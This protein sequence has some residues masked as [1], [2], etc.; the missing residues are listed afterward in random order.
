MARDQVIQDPSARDLIEHHVLKKQLDSRPGG[1]VN[2]PPDWQSSPELPTSAEV[3][4]TEPGHLPE[5]SDEVPTKLQYLESQYWLTRFEGTELLRRAVNHIRARPNMMEDSDF[6]IYTQVHV[7]GYL[8]ARS[9]AACR[10]SFSTERSPSKVLWRHSKRLTPQTLVALSPRSDNFKSQCFVAVVAE[11][12]LNGGVEPNFQA[13][14][15]ENTPPRIEIFWANHEDAILDPSVDL[16]MV[17]AKGGYFEPI[18]HALVGLQHA[19]LYE[20]K[21]DKYIVEECERSLPAAYFQEA[22]QTVHFPIAASQFD[23]SQT[24]AFNCMTSRELAIVQGPPGTGKTFTSIVAIQSY[25]QTLQAN[26]G[27][28]EPPS[29]V[30]VSAQTNHALDQ[31]L[32]R[33]IQVGANVVRLG[34]RSK[35]A[36]ICERSMYNLEQGSKV[37]AGPAQGENSRKTTLRNLKDALSMCFPGGLISADHLYR[38]GLLSK[39]QF[40]SLRDNDWET[41]AQPSAKVDSP[42]SSDNPNDTEDT[43]GGSIT[44]WLEDC[45]E[46]DQTYVYRPPQGQAEVTPD[47]FESGHEYQPPE[48]E[49]EERERLKGE[50]VSTEFYWTGSVPGSMSRNSAWYFQGCKYLRKY[51]D[52]YQVKPPQ[53]GMV[54]R[55]LRQQLIE[56]ITRQFPKLLQV[57]QNACDDIKINKWN[58]Q[59]K[60]VQHEGIEVLGCTTT[61]LTKY[62]GLISAMKPRIL[63]IEEAA[64]TREANITSALYPSLDQVALVGD[65]QQLV[66][67]VDVSELKQHPYHLDVSLFERLVHLNLPYSMLKVQRRTIPIIRSVVNTFYPEIEDHESVKDPRI[68]PPVPGMGGQNL[69]WFQHQWG[70]S[71]NAERS[72]YNTNEAA[73]IVGFVK[74][75]VQNGVRPSQ[76]TVLTYYNGQVAAILSMLRR[77]ATLANFNPTKEWSVRTVDGFQGEENEIIILSLVRSPASPHHRPKAGFVENENRA[78]V[79]TSRARCGMYIFGNS[80]NLLKSTPESAETWQRVYDVFIKE[81]CIGYKLPVACKKHDRITEL[82]HPADWETIPGGGCMEPCNETCPEGHPCEAICHAANKAQV[83]CREMCEK[84]LPCN[85]RCGSFCG[86]PCECPRGCNKPALA[87]VDM[88]LRPPPTMAAG[89]QAGEQ[90][91]SSNESPRGRGGRGGRGAR[92]ARGAP[93]GAKKGKKFRGGGGQP[94]QHMTIS[95]PVREQS[96]QETQGQV[97]NH[98]DE[99]TSEDLIEFG[100]HAGIAEQDGQVNWVAE[101]HAATTLIPDLVSMTSVFESAALSEESTSDKWS[102]QKVMERD[103]ALQL[104]LKHT[105]LSP[106]RRS[107][108]IRQTFYSTASDRAGCRQPIVTEHIFPAPQLQQRPMTV[109]SEAGSAYSEQPS[110]KQRVLDI[111]AGFDIVD[112]LESFSSTSGF[113]DL[114]QSGPEREQ[115]SGVDSLLMPLIQFD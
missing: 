100:Y 59:V 74:Y 8:F 76:I 75:L 88:P 27:K 77:S 70:D 36:A 29:L 61:G 89:N 103:R 87:E 110:R 67:G 7:Q 6:Y 90:P 34:G 3:M 52:L 86:T 78:V 114:R 69:W 41:A 102:P 12:C 21:F 44:A 23:Y 45:V 9:G 109:R 2:G 14:E 107:T 64:E 42:D 106:T 17:E 95:L 112:S 113:G 57:Y 47:G 96:T 15:D 115:V 101:N 19:A 62:R 98:Q 82:G 38:E 63:M 40:D 1:D 91:S 104:S 50:F 16:I 97:Q 72:Y 11:R 65:H 24:E 28:D 33:C 22:G 105:D 73:M 99:P 58:R 111:A 18:R 46:Q 93:R 32:E 49:D 43:C 10:I 53:R 79:A 37:R 48:D 56:K 51:S 31:L 92:G 84:L 81:G 4:G 83:K 55:C 85:H 25:I 94:S 20:S 35:V 54:Y 66:P 13:G 30:V 26:K 80:D 71:Q 60:V 5:N 108:R 68:H 39:E